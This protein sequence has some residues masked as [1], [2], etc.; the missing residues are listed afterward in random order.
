MQGAYKTYNPEP[1][2]VPALAIY[3]VPKSADELMRPWYKAE[4]PAEIRERVERLYPLERENVAR[5]AK[6]FA[7]FAERGRTSELSGGHD[8]FVTNPREVLEQIEA[9]VKSLPESALVGR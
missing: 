9:F 8:L 4:D 6:W 3:A 7:A 1:I 2:R 5:H